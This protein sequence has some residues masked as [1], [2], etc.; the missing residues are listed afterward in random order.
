MWVYGIFPTVLAAIIVILL[1]ISPLHSGSFNGYKFREAHDGAF[2]NICDSGNE[3]GEKQ[4]NKLKSNWI[5]IHQGTCLEK[6][7]GREDINELFLLLHKNFANGNFEENIAYVS[8]KLE[9]DK[10][11]IF[12]H[13]ANFLVSFIDKNEEEALI[14]ALLMYDLWPIFP[15]SKFG[16]AMR[17]L[18]YNYTIDRR[19]LL[20]FHKICEKYGRFCEYT[21]TL[22]KMEECI[23][24]KK[25]CW[26]TKT[27]DVAYFLREKFIPWTGLSE[28]NVLIEVTDEFNGISTIFRDGKEYYLILRGGE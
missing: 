6:S 21:S 27:G 12:Y 13:K 11:N 20:V 2:L 5:R 1:F 19:I 15:I 25:R 16:E 10:F 9:E 26:G 8:K 3:I 14:S 4:K 17:I 18:A 23:E 22:S 24:N 28:G 7:V